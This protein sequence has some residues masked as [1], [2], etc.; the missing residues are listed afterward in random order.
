MS[1]DL[2]NATELNDYPGAPFA[3]SIVDA[4]VAAM[5]NE[6]GWHIAPVRTE[7]I[8]RDTDGGTILF[9][10]TLRLISVN[11]IRDLTGDTPRVI[12]GWR[13]SRTGMVSGPWWPCGFGAV[14]ADITHGYEETPKELL[15][16]IAERCQLASLNSGVRQESAG[17]ESISYSASGSVTPEAM[18]IWSRYQIPEGYR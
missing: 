2:V 3:E 8:V 18:R 17:S 5:R 12:D 7:T 6:A 14:E 13:P 11:E 4:V 9:L 15:L 16:V 1:N 10:P